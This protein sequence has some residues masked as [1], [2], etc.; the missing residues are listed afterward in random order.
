M[1][2]LAWGGHHRSRHPFGPHAGGRSHFGR[3]REGRS[4]RVFESG[5]LR[6]LLLAV[7]AEKPS[8]G[9]ELIKEVE[10]RLGG[11]YSP[12]PG[13]VYPTLTWLEEL[14]YAT[15]ETKGGGKKLYGIT[16]EGRAY[17]ASQKPALDSILARMAAASARGGRFAPQILRAMDNLRSAL[18]YRLAEGP[19][20]EDDVRAVVDALDGAARAVERRV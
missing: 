15:V 18:K 4:E 12:S 1:Y 8:H 2:H 16:E 10:E 3:H 7:I 19:L 17:L 14:G 20:S 5:D 6:I 9:Y 13:V 11:G